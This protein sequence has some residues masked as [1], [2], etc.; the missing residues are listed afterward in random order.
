MKTGCCIAQNSRQVFVRKKIDET[1][2]KEIAQ[3]LDI[4]TKIVA[5]HIPEAMKFLKQEFE[6]M[7]VKG[8][9]FFH[10]FV[11]KN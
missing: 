11:K 2:L 10:L 5:Y 1:S 8:M 3:E 6:K 9:I 4:T 7:Q